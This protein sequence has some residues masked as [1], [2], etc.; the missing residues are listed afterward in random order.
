V[1]K[2]SSSALQEQ[3]NILALT[4]M[5]NPLSAIIEFNLSVSE[6]LPSRE[7]SIP[8]PENLLNL[9]LGDYLNKANQPVGYAEV[10]LHELRRTSPKIL[11]PRIL[12]RVTMKQAM[13]RKAR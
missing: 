10:I 6:R 7:T 1:Q 4:A 3:A 12:E 5:L 8:I 13:V 9:A 11:Y 2:E